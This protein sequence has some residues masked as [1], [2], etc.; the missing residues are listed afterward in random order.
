MTFASPRLRPALLATLA[1]AALLAG[2]ATAS[3]PQADPTIAT[4]L[5]A[6]DREVKVSAMPED[7]RLAPHETGL[8]ANQATALEG[9]VRS[10]MM[11]QAREIVVRAP[12]SGPNARGANRV[13][14]DARD[15]L[16][17]LGVPANRITMSAYDSGGEDAAPV[18]ISFN[19]YAVEV[20]KCG[21]WRNLSSNADNRVYD[22]FG[23]AVTANMAA[24]VANPEDL[25][26]PRDMTP[27]DAQER[28]TVFDKYRKGEATGAARDAKASGAVS[29]VV[30]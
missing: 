3:G 2:C 27:T 7:I 20:P 26:R 21:N 22:N 10:W 11:A 17:S 23:C 9:F 6:W 13:A 4:P 25:L 1:A 8:S 12:D 29:Q 16:L 24:Q 30:N 19:R 5:D 14:W 28:A 18:V 15:R